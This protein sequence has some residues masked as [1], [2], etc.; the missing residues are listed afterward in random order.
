MSRY[1]NRETGSLAVALKNGGTLLIAGKS[2]VELTLE[3]EGSEDVCRA[4]RKGYLVRGKDLTKG[5]PMPVSPSDV[6]KDGAPAPAVAA[7]VS[8]SDMAM[9]D[10]AVMVDSKDS[11]SKK[12][13]A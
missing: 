7:E 4:V 6:T 12:R 5:D 10:M 8:A 1:Y 9:G 13:K 3:Q 2:W 11:S